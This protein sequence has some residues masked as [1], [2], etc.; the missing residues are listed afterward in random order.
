MSDRDAATILG[1]FLFFIA[2]IVVA[3]LIGMILVLVIKPKG[4]NRFG[5]PGKPQSFPGAIKTCLNRYADFSGRSSRSEFWW[6]FLF[7]FLVGI[8]LNLLDMSLKTNFF[9]YGSFGFLLPMLGVSMRRLHDINRRGWWV[10]LNLCLLP[11]V[12]YVLW[13][14]PAEKDD[15]IVAQVFE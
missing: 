14:R 3:N 6:F 10:L 5:K 4:R 13:A 7:T 12:L 2:Y 8:A 9:H 1:V 11:V 15:D